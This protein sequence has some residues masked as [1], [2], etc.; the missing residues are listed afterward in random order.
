M[1]NVFA[2][3]SGSTAIRDERGHIVAVTRLIRA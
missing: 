3:D 1:D 2:P